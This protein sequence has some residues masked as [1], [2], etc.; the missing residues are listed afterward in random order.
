M[1]TLSMVPPTIMVTLTS[2]S[3]VKSTREH[4]VTH[5][6]ETVAGIEHL[7]SSWVVAADVEEPFA[8][9]A[10]RAALVET[11][12]Q[13]SAASDSSV[14]LYGPG[15]TITVGDGAPGDP[16]VGPAD[17]ER[18]SLSPEVDLLVP[19]APTN[20]TVMQRWAGTVAVTTRTVPVAPGWE[21]VVR[22][23][24][25]AYQAELHRRW[26]VNLGILALLVSTGVVASFVFGWSVSRR[27]ARLGELTRNLPQ[28]IAANEAIIWPASRLH[29]TALLVENFR[30]MDA[31]LRGQFA[32]LV[33][34]REA[35]DAA[36]RAKSQFLANISHEIRTPMHSVLGLVNLVR[37]PETDAAQREEYLNEIDESGRM[38]VGLLDDI[39]DLS[40]IEAGMLA[41]RP[42]PVDLRKA[43]TEV[44]RAFD[45]AARERGIAL[46]AETDASLPHAIIADGVRLRQILLNLVGN[47]VKF[48]EH[49]SVRVQARFAPREPGAEVGTLT[50]RVV[51]TG[52]GIP[53]EERTRIFEPFT[54]QHDQDDRR[55]GGSGLGLAITARLV[56]AMNGSVAVTS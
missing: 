13:F 32:Q 27:A 7:I 43:V 53:P 54:Q 9:S 52:P 16:V 25:G 29:E 17:Y 48:T 2:R 28:R 39:L 1:I 38:L 23:D 5:V 15:E 36:N 3:A 47:A 46:T 50:L 56:S 26:L 49:G 34:A 21:M 40:R 20:V 8:G 6:E 30:A 44:L 19:P 35:A 51:D 14:T 45:A 42:V 11:I 18:R 4:I 12:A 10:R 31:S 37:D 24:F 22:T 55:Y 41:L 33:D